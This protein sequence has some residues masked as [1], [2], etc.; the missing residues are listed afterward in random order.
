MI[1]NSWEQFIL[2]KMQCVL[3][4]PQFFWDTIVRAAKLSLTPFFSP[5]CN[6]LRHHREKAEN[7]SEIWLVE[8]A[9]GVLSTFRIMN[10]R[11]LKQLVSATDIKYLVKPWQKP[12]E[13]DIALF[14]R[15]LNLHACSVILTKEVAKKLQIDF[16][17]PIYSKTDRI[18]YSKK[19]KINS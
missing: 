18:T 7:T 2:T 6:T 5:A 15:A 14:Q 11:S 9:R 17:T 8:I 13:V 19:F 12:R 4:P 1:W 3:K 10:G 16:S